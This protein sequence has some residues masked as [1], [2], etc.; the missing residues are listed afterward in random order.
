M[1]KCPSC[2]ASPLPGTAYGLAQGLAV[3]VF[4]IRNAEPSFSAIATNTPP[5]AP[6]FNA[7]AGTGSQSTTT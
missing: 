4:L 3:H 1:L 7:S 6:F 2:V 5:P